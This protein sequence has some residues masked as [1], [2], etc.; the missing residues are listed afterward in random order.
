MGQ[1]HRQ[2]THTGEHKSN[3]SLAWGCVSVFTCEWGGSWCFENVQRLLPVEKH[4][5]SSG[6]TNVCLGAR[7]TKICSCSHPI[8]IEYLLCAQY[9]T[10]IGE[11]TVIKTKVKVAQ[12]CPTLCDPMAYTVHGILWARILE[13]APFL[14]SRG[15]SQPR[16]QTGVSCIAGGFF[17]NWAIRE[18]NQL[19][20]Q[21]KTPPKASALILG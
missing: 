6:P 20:R 4:H 10:R 19:T 1:R 16:N 13:W 14:F 8:F 15:S 7:V 17:T 3:F 18:A 21:S 12:S 5:Y 9:C 2:S 11:T